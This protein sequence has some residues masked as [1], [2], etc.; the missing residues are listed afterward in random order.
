MIA[1]LITIYLF[2]VAF[3]FGR[4]FEMERKEKENKIENKPNHEEN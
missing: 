4:A 2:V 3:Q 1:F